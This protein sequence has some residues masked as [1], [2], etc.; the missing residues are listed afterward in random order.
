MIIGTLSAFLR[1][2]FST[3]NKIF[4]GDT[5]SLTI[6]LV[7]S[8]LALKLLN[9]KEYQFNFEF[10]EYHDLPIIVLTIL[11]L[12]ISDL[13]RVVVIRIINNK[14]IYKPDKNH[15]HHAMISIGFSHRRASL[16]I[17]T[18]NILFTFFVLLTLSVYGTLPGILAFISTATLSIIFFNSITSKYLVKENI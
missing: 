11:F 10:I 16:V 4:M 14:A 7:L 17:N 15:I 8:I 3:T 12:P 13:M 5:G 6:G 2:N 18:L 1:Y 9:I